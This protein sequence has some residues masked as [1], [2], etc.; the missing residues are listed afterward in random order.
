MEKGERM[1]KR[2]YEPSVQIGSMSE[3]AQCGSEWFIWHG[4]TTHRAVLISLQ[5]RVLENAI[6]NGYVWTAKRK[7]AE[8]G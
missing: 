4:K 7:E 1:S 5:Y 3:F 6:N 2:M 8:D